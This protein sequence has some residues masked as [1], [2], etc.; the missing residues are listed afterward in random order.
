MSAQLTLDALGGINWDSLRLEQIE[1]FLADALPGKDIKQ[2]RHSSR[3]CVS[4]E[5]KDGWKLYA[6][7]SLDRI[8]DNALRWHVY[9]ECVPP[10]GSDYWT[11]A[12]RFHDGQEDD[13]RALVKAQS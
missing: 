8:S 2:E 5:C 12:R 6:C 1:Q 4:V 13:L 10:D 9:V 7:P 3:Q 11:Y